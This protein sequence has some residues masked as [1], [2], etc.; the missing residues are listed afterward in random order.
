MIWSLLDGRSGH[1]NQ[2]IGLTEAIARRV[3]VQAF[4]IT[5]AQ[6]LR[7]LRSLIPGRL[8]FAKTL[9]APDMPLTCR[10]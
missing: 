6:S 5:I 9:P 8:S 2:V 10:Y 3:S 1:E 4:D 7:G